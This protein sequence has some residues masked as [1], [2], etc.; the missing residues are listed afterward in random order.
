[1]TRGGI[2]LAACLLSACT[3]GSP[4]TDPAP[5]TPKTGVTISG[6]ASFGIVKGG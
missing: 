6:H 1:M 5:E 4:T 3:G 2:L